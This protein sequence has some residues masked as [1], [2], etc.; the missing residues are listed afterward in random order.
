MAHA[1][2]RIWRPVGEERVLLMAGRT[3]SYAIE[4]RGEYVFGIVEGA[5]MRSRRG[6]ERRVVQPGQLVA[7]DPSSAHAGTPA[8]SEPWSSRL[9]IVETAG[10]AGLAGDEEDDLHPEVSFPDP[11]VSDLELAGS[12]LRMHAALES[13]ATRLE[14]DE[15]LAGWLRALVERCSTARPTAR[16]LS[17]RDQNALRLARDYLVER[18]DRN[19][20]LDELAAAAGIG[21]FRLIR[22]V[23]ERTGLPPHAL[24]LAYRLQ[25]ARR[26]LEAGE[27][28][29]ETAIATGFSDQS[30]LHRQFVRSVGLP[31]GAYQRCF[32]A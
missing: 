16:V 8:A 22:L 27:P 5:P 12:F 28:I 17:G 18:L 13:A 9:L 3:S 19:V 29:A 26:R 11:V 20:A 32:V 23:R 6:R 21:K 1:Q 30:H 25:A 7:W 24:Q 31:P 14:R 10:L 4:P 2:V 15:R